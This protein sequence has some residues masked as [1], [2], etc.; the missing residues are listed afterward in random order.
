MDV[1][2]TIEFI[3]QLQARAEARAEKADARVDKAEARMVRTDRRIDA[4]A[5]LVQQGMRMLAKSSVEM[6]EIRAAQTVTAASIAELTRSQKRT[7]VSLA[8]LAQAQKATERS[9]KR[10]LDSMRPGR[11]GPNGR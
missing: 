1:E 11:N 7:D 5:K 9:L 2:R 6:A 8:E 4:I 10:F 3:L